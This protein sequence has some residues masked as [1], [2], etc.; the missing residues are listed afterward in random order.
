MLVCRVCDHRTLGS[1]RCVIADWNRSEA[2][3]EGCQT[4]AWKS[5]KHGCHFLRLSE[6]SFSGVGAGGKYLPRL[7]PEKITGGVDAVNAHVVHR[8]ATPRDGFGQANIVGS[9][10]SGKFRAEK[11]QA[12]EFPGFDQPNCLEVCFLEVQAI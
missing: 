11:F 6:S 5:H 7:F 2:A 4:L 10:L 8:A 9:N 12:S 3:G 1:N